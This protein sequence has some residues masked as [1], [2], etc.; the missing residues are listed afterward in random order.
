MLLVHFVVRSAGKRASSIFAR[1][2]IVVLLA[3]LMVAACDAGLF[4]EGV[5][6][7]SIEL[8]VTDVE[9]VSGKSAVIRA[10]I[11]DT[12]GKP[13]AVGPGGFHVQWSSSVEEIVSVAL[14]D[15]VTARVR[16]GAGGTSEITAT[17]Q[18]S[19][20]QAGFLALL[21]RK[22]PGISASAT[23][24]VGPAD[25]RYAAGN[26]QTGE[27]ASTLLKELVVRAVDADGRGVANVEIKFVAHRD[28]GTL[29]PAKVVTDQ[30]GR[31]RSRWT[32]GQNAGEMKAEARAASRFKLS[33]VQFT[34]SAATTPSPVSVTVTPEAATLPTRSTLQ[35]SAT[36]EDANGGL[37]TD[38]E[39]EWSSSNATVAT[40]DQNGL[41]TANRPGSATVI[42]SSGGVAA[43]ASLTVE[44]PPPP[45]P[46]VIPAFPGAQG[47]G[48]TA[49]KDCRSKP[50]QVIFVD[51][52]NFTGAGSLK[53]AVE[54]VAHSDSFSVVI[55]RT[56]GVVNTYTDIR[57]SS[58][59]VY[60]AGQTAPGDGF[61]LQDD[62][63]RSMLYFGYNDSNDHV[64]RFLR[65]WG[66]STGTSEYNQV[67]IR[68]NSRLVLDH[69]SIH[70]SQDS[71]Y[72]IQPIR[73]NLRNIT[74]QNTMSCSSGS[75]GFEI[76][77]RTTDAGDTEGF[78]VHHVYSCHA[79]HRLPRLSTGADDTTGVTQMRRKVE[80]ISNMTYKRYG[81][82]TGEVVYG[83]VDFRHNL[84]RADANPESNS[85]YWRWEEHTSCLAHPHTPPP[86]VYMEGNRNAT[87]TLRQDWSLMG[88][89]CNQS[90]L[91]TI[92]RFTRLPQPPFPVTPTL[93]ANLPATLLPHVGASRRLA[94]DGTWVNMR[95][96][97]DAGFVN[98]WIKGTGPTD[99]NDVTDTALGG[100][101][102]LRSGRPCT[103]TDNDG[104]PNAWEERFFGCATC[105]NAAELTPSG[106]LVIEH[107]LNGTDPRN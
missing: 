42:A 92:Q 45:P 73:G 83:E 82:R 66:R 41:V 102:V 72:G 69:M 103:D 50:L 52:T 81:S 33:P 97:L 54:N 79:R 56:G 78:S 51:N 70:F 77:R 64:W 14:L 104:I 55:F 26:A 47:W 53:E 105:A 44:E 5:I 65:I 88:N 75:T 99:A 9:L 31:A 100:Y 60:V 17:V 59:C 46:S 10:T 74:I 2:G 4:V 39:L 87:G 89:R 67:R 84:L 21:Q 43:A 37:L 40:V 106:Y 80:W 95:D 1:G 34:A 20:A 49:L 29:E 12:R 101:P 85:A 11:K 86:S 8:D 30:D 107:Y 16:G 6:P 71:W 61:A 23:V 38:S 22:S 15:A 18:Y 27:V 32:L 93:A 36:V 58:D 57:P 90:P 98:D 25:L 76:K 7:A 24:H 13:L 94:C 19:V 28:H 35:F 68:G 62:Q 96:G 48:A 63:G 91:S 3:V